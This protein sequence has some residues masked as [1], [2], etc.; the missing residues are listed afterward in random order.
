MV[1]RPLTIGAI[2]RARLIARLYIRHTAIAARAIRIKMAAR[3]IINKG[4]ARRRIR[5]QML[6]GQLNI[7]AIA[8]MIGMCRRSTGV[9]IMTQ[10]EELAGDRRM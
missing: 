2:P 7:G 6:R 1:N 10:M 9:A 3:A 5:P 4:I 8:T